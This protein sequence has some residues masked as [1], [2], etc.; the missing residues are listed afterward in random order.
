M[1]GADKGNAEAAYNAFFSA[2]F[3][4]QAPRPGVS[5]PVS[6]TINGGI[7]NKEGV[8]KVATEVSDELV[9]KLMPVFDAVS[10][11]DY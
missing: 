7:N 4:Q 3:Q 10:S 6:V 5:I 8:R 2:P 1:T 11:G 9:R